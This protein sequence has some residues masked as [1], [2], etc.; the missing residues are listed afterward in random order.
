MNL[1]SQISKPLE[2]PKS[3]DT[4]Y[5]SHLTLQSQDGVNPSTPQNKQR[6]AKS[7]D[8]RTP[9]LFLNVPDEVDAQIT[10]AEVMPWE[11]PSPFE[12]QAAIEQMYLSSCHTKIRKQDTTTTVDG[13]NPLLLSPV[14][15]QQQQNQNHK[16]ETCIIFLVDGSGSVTEEDFNSMT[17]FM[18]TAATLI[19]STKQPHQHIHLGVIQFSNEVRVELPPTQISGVVLETGNGRGC[20]G[21]INFQ[22]KGAEG[23]KA[24]EEEESPFFTAVESMVRINGGTN[25]AAA[26]QKAGQLFKNLST[27]HSNE[28]PENSTRAPPRS[29]S[30]LKKVIA[31]LTDGRIDSFQSHEAK[32]ITARLVDEQGNVALHAF[33]VGRGVDRVELLRIV[34]GAC[35]AREDAANRYL[36]LM[37]LED[38]PW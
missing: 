3:F 8:I 14:A 2:A 13:T 19:K 33:G 30:E 6:G 29:T 11:K 20:E 24:E 38:A 18:L 31:L 1:R 34:G 35:P 10:G 7:A 32:E 4:D 26:I 16:E 28:D 25:I 21:K 12:I 27:S 22:N 5:T 23:E 9:D 37:V 15:P 36:P 17:S